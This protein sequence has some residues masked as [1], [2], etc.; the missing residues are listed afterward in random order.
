VRIDDDTTVIARMVTRIVVPIVLV[1]ALAL[2]FQ[3]HNLPGG[4]FIAGVL[5][6]TAVALVY[7]IYGLDSVR[8]V[9]NRSP[10]AGT[11][12][13][14]MVSD[15][16]RLFGGGLGLAVTAGMLPFV[17]YLLSPVLPARFSTA[18]TKAFLEQGFV[19]RKGIPVVKDLPKGILPELEL[20]SAFVFDLGVYFVVVGSLLAILAVVGEE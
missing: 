6:T 15:Y 3:G 16:R 8:D 12:E 18:A 10:D 20:A 11:L 9:L 14:G 2:L 17:W 13:P 4:G 7:I 1:T 19:K 5:T